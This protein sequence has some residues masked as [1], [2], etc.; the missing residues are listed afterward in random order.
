MIEQKKTIEREQRVPRFIQKEDGCE[1][2]SNDGSMKVILSLTR[3]FNGQM[4]TEFYN[5][6]YYARDDEREYEKIDT[7]LT[8]HSIEEYMGKLEN[9]EDYSEAYRDYRESV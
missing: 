3:S 6:T 1:I 8:F 7:S 2:L 5:A 4:E 9:N